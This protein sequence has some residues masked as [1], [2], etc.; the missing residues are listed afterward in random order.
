[1]KL[2]IEQRFNLQKYSRVLLSTVALRQ[3]I[4]QFWNELAF[5]DEEYN[6]FNIS[7]D[8]QTGEVTSNDPSYVIEVSEVSPVVINA[9]KHYIADNSESK[10]GDQMFKQITETFDLVI[11][12]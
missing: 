6:K 9:M 11:S 10:E 7:V 5:T 2:T 12:G 8:V 1:M 4:Q 3:A